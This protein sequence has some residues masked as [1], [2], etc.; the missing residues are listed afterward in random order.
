MGKIK[1]ICISE[2]RGTAKKFVDEATFHA[3]FGIVGD[4]HAGDWHRQVSFLGQAEIDAFKNRGANVEYGAFGENIVAE[5]FTLKTLPIGTRL[6]SGDVFFEI[7]QIG[8]DCHSHCAIYQQVGDCIMPREGVFARVIH[9]GKIK[10]GDELEIATEKIPLDAA[11]VTV[12]DRG[13]YGLRD[14]DRSGDTC[15]EI[16]T[17]AGYKVVSRSIVPDVTKIIVDRLTE[18][19]NLGVGLILTTGG[20][21][22]SPRDVTPEATLKVCDRLAP[23]IA[24]AMRNFSMQITKRAM[25]SRAVSG[26][27]K[28]S[29]I[30]NLP[31]SVK[32]VD[33]CLNF[34]L[35]ELRH[36]I[37]IL[38]GDD[39]N[40]G[41]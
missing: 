40:C 31:G 38:R 4:A 7:T 34:I 28:R 13:F 35:P 1:A 23:G 11:V 29:L 36:G 8:K 26:I 30:V 24:E 16:L 20:T 27:R 25:L 6:K 37:E 12:S 32:A 14:E 9:G 41:R 5:G 21:G 18:L 17:A 19:S 2:N 33:E 10:V 15:E 3:E 22:F 39:S